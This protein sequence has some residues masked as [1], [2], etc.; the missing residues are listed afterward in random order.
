MIRSIAAYLS[1]AVAASLLHIAPAHSQANAAGSSE[2]RTAV[3]RT[4][5][6]SCMRAT[7][8]RWP[9]PARCSAPSALSCASRARS[10]RPRASRGWRRASC[11]ARPRPSASTAAPST[12]SSGPEGRINAW[13]MDEA[14]VDGVEDQPDAGIINDRKLP[15]TKASAL[16]AERARRRREHRDRL[17]C[18]RVPA[19]GAGPVRRRSRATAASTDF[20]DGKAPERRSPPPVPR[21]WSPS[22]WSTTSHAGQGLGARR[23]TT[24]APLRA[25]RPRIGAQ[26][27]RRPGLALARRARRRAAG[28]GAASQDQEDEH[29]CFSDNTH[30][31]VVANARGIQNVWL[32]QYRRAR[33]QRA[34]G[35][36]AARPGGRR[37]PALAER[38][39]RADRR[40]GGGGRSDPARRSTGD[41]GASATRRAASASQANR[42][43][44]GTGEGPGRRGRRPRHH[45]PDAGA[46]EMTGHVPPPWRL[47][48]VALAGAVGAWTGLVAAQ[49]PRPTT[50][51]RSVP[52]APPPC[53]P[54]A[55]RVLVSRRQPERRGAHPLRRSATPSSSATGSRRRRP[56]GARRAGPA[57]H[58]A[59]L[60]RLP[61][62]GRPRRAAADA[63]RRERAEQPVAPA[64]APLGP[65]RDRPHAGVRP[66]P[67]YGDQF[68]NAAIHGREAGRRGDDPRD[69]RCTAVSPTARP[70]RCTSRPTRSASSATDPLRRRRHDQP[71]HRA[72]D[73][74]R[75]PARGDPRSRD[76]GQRAGAGRHARADQGHAQPRVGRVRQA[77]M[78][79]RFGWKANVASLAHQTAAAFVGDIGITSSASA[80]S[81]HARAGG[82][83]GGAARR[84]QGG[85]R[86]STTRRSTTS[87]STP[88]RSR[89][90]RAATCATRRCCA[91]QKLFAQAQCAVCHRPS[92]VTGE[93]ALPAPDQQGAARARRSI[94]T[95]TCCCTTWAKAWPTAGPTS[96]PT[97][98]NGDAAAVGRRP[99]AGRQRPPAPAARRPRR[100]RARGHPLARRRSARRAAS[101]CWR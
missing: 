4:T 16:D 54:T 9:P 95:P 77:R 11:T 91:G 80:R 93:V 58:R 21:Q 60:R 15:I 69:A 83:P 13:P 94:P 79:G 71:A 76:P 59:L 36:V 53:S 35:R 67:V 101:R 62:A 68:N 92:Y 55:A 32:G 65:G 98:A 96:W 41:H 3:A 46:A 34:E 63:Q 84:P 25:G 74:R 78:L 47:A 56:P 19:V 42:Q 99:D 27:P 57:L 72:A 38:T 73:H 100:R 2:L 33:R 52:A 20:V 39:T 51:R 6:P 48:A 44:L 49:A 64:A 75:G 18:H 61:R 89:R 8:T 50:P 10:W 85:R 22:C 23:K 31:D 87:S 12:T 14:Y 26:D 29:S 24:T 66:E 43:P 70:T 40:I 28:S 86:R 88:P 30:R 81:L 97:A 17:A 7:R 90:R 45:P 1:A 82:L 37:D 5:P